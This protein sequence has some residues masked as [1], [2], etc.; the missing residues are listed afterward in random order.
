M[1]LVFIHGPLMM[2]KPATVFKF[3]T[4]SAQSLQNLKKQIIYFASPRV[5]ND[6]YD[7]SLPPRISEPVVQELEQ[8]RD[9]TMQSIDI[10]PSVQNDLK[11]KSIE[12]IGAIVKRNADSIFKD[13][14]KNFKETAGISCFSQFNNDLLMW[15]HYGGQYK[16]FC[17]EFDTEFPPFTK[18]TKVKYTDEMPIIN[19]VQALHNENYDQFMELFCT[20]SKSWIYENEWRVFHKEA[21]TQFAYEDAALKSVYFGPDIDS[22]SLEIVCLIL[23]GQNPNVRFWRGKRSQERF[24]VLF[25]EFLYTNHIEAKNKGLI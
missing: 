6:P 10:P 18:M 23:Q 3:E 16:G 12:E 17:L 15:A 4:F 13:K 14:A 19:A 21:G 9:M 22:Q 24:E 2:E 1:I 8:Y 20:K 7:C 25:D 11:N 5:F